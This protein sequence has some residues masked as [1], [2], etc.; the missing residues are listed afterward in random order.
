MRVMCDE[1]DLIM[2]NT[3]IIRDDFFNNI[4]ISLLWRLILRTV[5]NGSI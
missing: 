2:Q 1:N 5:R 4:E 3:M